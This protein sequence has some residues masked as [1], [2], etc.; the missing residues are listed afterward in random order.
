MKNIC[1]HNK[2]PKS[3][4]YTVLNDPKNVKLSAS[5]YICAF[6]HTPFLSFSISL[7]LLFLILRRSFC[8]NAAAHL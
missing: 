1:S 5:L 3:I 2:I 8:L 7:P 6:D 4:I